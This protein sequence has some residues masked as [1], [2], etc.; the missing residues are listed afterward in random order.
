MHYTFHQLQIFLKVIETRSITNAS[1]ELFMTQPA[2]SIQLKKFQEQFKIPLT[3]IVGRNIRIT[4]FGFEIADIAKGIVKEMD[5]LTLRT[6]EY[7]GKFIGRLKIT[8][9][10]TGKYVIPFFLPDFLERY[11]GID[12]LLDVTNKT[13]VVE[14][15]KN[16]EVDFAV[17]SVLPHEIEVNEELLIENRLYLIGTK[18]NYEKNKPLIYR[19]KGSATRLEM[20]Q[21]FQET[22]SKERKKMEL[23]SNEAVKQA[24]IAGL[25][26]SIIPLIGIKNE[27]LNES[28][29]II[30]KKGLPLKTEWRLIWLKDKKLSPVAEAY[31]EFIRQEKERIVQTHFKWYLDF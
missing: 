2:V 21:H 23:T 9:A 7:E 13:A 8:A 16:N 27:L 15:L 4:D 24:I 1:E 31:L 29:H 30:E 18:E 3:E 28:L 12:L 10:S 22:G 5:L 20:E 11:P 25:G 14:S 26:H 19:E 17:V 6:K